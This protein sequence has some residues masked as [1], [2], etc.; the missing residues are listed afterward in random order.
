MIWNE[1]RSVVT[2]VCQVILKTFEPKYILSY[3]MSSILIIFLSN[4]GK[5]YAAFAY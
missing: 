2:R 5:L 3:K 1:F 4:V